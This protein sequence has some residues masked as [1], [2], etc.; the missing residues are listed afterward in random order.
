M[1]PI[2]CKIINFSLYLFSLFVF[3][4]ERENY[5]LARTQKIISGKS[6]TQYTLTVL[7][8]KKISKQISKQYSVFNI[9]HDWLVQHG[10]K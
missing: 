1:I 7:Y 9:K 5:F 8:D 10:A 3:F 4:W 2:D 6:I